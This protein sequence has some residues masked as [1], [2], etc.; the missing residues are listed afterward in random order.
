MY[1]GRYITAG[2]LWQIYYGN[3]SIADVY[4]GRYI[5]YHKNV[6]ISTRVQRQKL[7]IAAPE[8]VCCN[9]S[10]QR[11]Q[12]PPRESICQA[13]NTCMNVYGASNMC[14]NMYEAPNPPTPSAVER[15]RPNL[16][17]S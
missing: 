4:Y 2:V 17:G 13:Y 11:A 15:V 16:G 3:Y 10:P 12:G 8:S 7:S 14:M 1:F 9:A 5:A 6:H